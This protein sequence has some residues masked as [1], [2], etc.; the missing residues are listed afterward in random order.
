MLPWLGRLVNEVTDMTVR[1]VEGRGSPASIKKTWKDFPK[2]QIVNIDIKDGRIIVK[3]SKHSLI[4]KLGKQ[5]N[6]RIKSI[7]WKEGV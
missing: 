3:W 5:F 2:S 7:D 4:W 1:Y 6:L